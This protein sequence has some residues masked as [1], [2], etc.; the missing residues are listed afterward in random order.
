MT[1]TGGQE[2]ELKDDQSVSSYDKKEHKGYGD[3]DRDVER[4]QVKEKRNTKTGI[5]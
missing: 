3:N 1:G 5:S 4:E 2:G